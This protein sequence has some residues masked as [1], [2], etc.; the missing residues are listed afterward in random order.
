MTHAGTSAEKTA[1]VCSAFG[2]QNAS[3][4][5]E[6]WCF[7][8]GTL[9]SID[10]Y[11]AAARTCSSFVPAIMPNPFFATGGARVGRM[12]A[13]WPLA[14][15]TATADRLAIR[16]TIFGT[17]E[18]AADQV[19]SI[20][21]YTMIPVIGWGIQIR[22]NVAEYPERFIFWCIGNPDNVL[23]G[24]QES[25]FGPHASSAD[26]PVRRGMAFRWSAVIAAI[27]VWNAAFLFGFPLLHGSK[28]I[29]SIPGPS[30]LLPLFLG[31]VL[32]IAT[33][34]SPALQRLVLKP[35]RSVKEVRPFLRLLAVVFGFMLIVFSM[36]FGLAALG[37][38]GH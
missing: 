25:G 2:Q 29:Q 12:N 34:I 19:S 23:R 9:P 21:K 4:A 28:S 35:N 16:I 22:H 15:L 3:E 30:I 26:A 17:Y 24:I 8:L 5:R 31:F 14:K 33:P 27:A 1:Q 38:A 7:L 18:F 37:Q 13:S 36:V 11:E 6:S 32:S 20:E 10:F